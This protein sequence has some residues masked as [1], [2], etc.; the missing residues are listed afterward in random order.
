[1]SN[2]SISTVW[3]IN[4]NASQNRYEIFLKVAELGN[5]TLAAEAL[6]YTQSGVS[7][8]VA[9]MEREAGCML[10]HR[11]KTG[12]TLTANGKELLPYIQQLVN[13]QHALDQAMDS[14]S[15]RVSGTLR[16]GSFTS[17]TAIHMPGIMQGF[18]D[19]YPDVRIELVNGPYMEIEQQI[20]SGQIDCGFLSGTEN[21]E[22]DFHPLLQDEMFALSAPG[23]AP[24]GDASV[25]L[26][27]LG[28]YPLISQ[29][30]RSDRDV[31]K[32]FRAAG[33]RPHTR[34]ILD[35]DISVMGM[36]AQGMGIALMPEMMVRTASFDLVQIPLEPRQF[37]TIGIA[38]LPSSE[39]TLLV[40]TFIGFCEGYV[41]NGLR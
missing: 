29:F 14:L 25:K 19:L 2:I 8:A 32:I 34:F 38:S 16:I 9:A 13:R 3:R 6:S 28:E 41:T 24:S 31:H 27:K 20:V 40:R 37:R 35:D 15:N 21:G 10:F 12:V 5:I 17:F 23:H 36:V 11:S 26:K 30:R 39:T 4:M 22:L 7:H 33:V 1:M 18:E